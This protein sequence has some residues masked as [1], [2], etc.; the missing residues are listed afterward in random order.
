MVGCANEEKTL[1][2]HVKAENTLSGYET[3]LRTF[4][5]SEYD[6]EISTRLVRVAHQQ[7]TQKNAIE[8]YVEFLK[9]HPDSDI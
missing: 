8:G 4:P 5:K 6:Q 3:F 7:T 9:R 2:R 1:Y